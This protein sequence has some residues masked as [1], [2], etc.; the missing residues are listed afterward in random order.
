[1]LTSPFR[2]YV[3]DADE[4]L[5]ENGQ[6]SAG[7]QRP[8][9]DQVVEALVRTV[10]AIRAA[11][12]KAVIVAPPPASGMNMG[13]C[14][15]RLSSGKIFIGSDD[16]SIPRADYLKWDK[17]VLTVLGRASAKAHVNVVGLSNFLCDKNR[18]RTS[19]S[20]TPLYRDQGHLSYDGSV[21]LA[22][23]AKG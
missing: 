11:G 5:V 17:D 3:A 4:L 23:K 1:V 2:D 15:E 16:C 20:G 22:D 8:A 21:V 6:G 18:C 13:L 19:L 9:V 10:D 7:L 12:K 14:H